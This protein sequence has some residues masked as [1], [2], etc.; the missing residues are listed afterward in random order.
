MVTAHADVVVI[1]MGPGG[2][3]VAG[4]LAE[5]GLDVVGVE[6]ELLGGECPYW[7][8]VPSKM[9][10]RASNLIAEAR[11]VPG[12]AGDATVTPDWAPVAH[13]IR[14]EATDDWN[15]RVAVERFEAKGG[16]FVRGAGR[17]D[18][19]GRVAVG[20]DVFETRRA[21]VLATG[22]A[23][24]IPPIPGLGDVPFWTNRE[25]IEAKD[26]PKSLV[27]LGGGAIGLELSQVFERFGVQVRVVEALDRLLPPEEP[28]AS[29]LIEEVVTREGMEIYTGHGATNAARDG[30]EV[31]LTL[32]DGR[33]VR[34]EQL[35]V[36]TGRRALLAPLGLASVGI[37][38]QARWV[39]VDGR[40]RAGAGLWA[41]G[42][43]TGHGAFTHIAMYQAGIATAD[44]L[45][46]APAP[47]DYRA[48]PRVTFTDPEVGSVGL[49][50]AAAREQGINVRT[51]LAQIPSTA[52]G[53][54]HKAGNE[55]FIKVVEDAG[56][57]VLVGATSVG[58][59]G[60]EVL[61]MLV[62]AV[63]AEIPVD[64]LQHMIYAYP[65]FHRGIEDA[66]RDLR[67]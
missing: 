24:A 34:G 7:G 49:N 55:G 14:A 15:D 16:R 42:D 28:E 47:A 65:T 22:S 56:R 31:V 44:I 52:R 5:A 2:E 35:L 67:G 25:A 53:W 41:V 43:L 12:I 61:S 4:R 9:M 32:D 33:A 46:E 39:T 63:H 8:C 48:L 36:A 54:I 17:L 18:G 29:A 50:D 21:V 26:L 62:L 66:L 40:M 51:G 38:E 1:G 20:N 64:T 57:G 60:G 19:P 27:V 10:I 45:G 37:D 30:S 13:R 58:P 11:R 6:N 59:V 3:D 23:A